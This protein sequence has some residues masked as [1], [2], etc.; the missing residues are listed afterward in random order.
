VNA[1]SLLAAESGTVR[2]ERAEVVESPRSRTCWS[3]TL[4]GPRPSSSRPR[5]TSVDRFQP[6][7]TL[8]PRRMVSEVKK[9]AGDWIYDAASIGYPGPVLRGRPIAE[10]YNL[11]AGGSVSISMR[12][13]VAP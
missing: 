3:S 11:D 5:K 7:L 9:L 1:K 8:T 4:R 10:P 2:E 13:S 12:H 6:G